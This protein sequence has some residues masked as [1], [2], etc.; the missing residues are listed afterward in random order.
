MEAFPQ[1]RSA[2]DVALG[3]G[4]PLLVIDLMYGGV[5]IAGRCVGAG[6]LGAQMSGVLF[7]LMAVLSATFSRGCVGGWYVGE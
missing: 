3:A 2:V 6:W 4:Q 1:L 7:G 5:C